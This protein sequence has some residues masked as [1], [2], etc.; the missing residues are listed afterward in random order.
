MVMVTS[1]RLSVVMTPLMWCRTAVRVRI[2]GA[3]LL[4]TSI[5]G[6]HKVPLEATTIFQPKQ[7]TRELSTH[8]S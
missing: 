1:R 7:Q 3:E 2:L 4:I 6:G 5:K 8:V